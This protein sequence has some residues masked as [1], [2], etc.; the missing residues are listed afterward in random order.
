MPC[1]QFQAV[2]TQK[3]GIA[4]RIVNTDNGDSCM[5]EVRIILDQKVANIPYGP[6]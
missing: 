2:L 5:R 1:I 3:V 4:Y 6:Q